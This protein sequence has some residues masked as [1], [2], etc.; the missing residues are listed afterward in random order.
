MYVTKQLMKRRNW[1]HLPEERKFLF[2]VTVPECLCEMV[3]IYKGGQRISTHW[4]VAEA[5]E[6]AVMG[7]SDEGSQSF[8]LLPT[9]LSSH[10][11]VCLFQHALTSCHYG[12]SSRDYLHQIFGWKE[13]KSTRERIKRA[14]F[15]QY[16]TN[17]CTIYIICICFLKHSYMFQCLIALSSESYYYGKVTNQLICS[18]LS[19]VPLQAWTG[20]EGG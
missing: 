4:F 7:A 10:M 8:L 19:V 6:M 11:D 13:G 16:I 15:L 9:V 12:H 2:L 1:L 5:T 18:Q 14:S 17:K 20:L 3:P